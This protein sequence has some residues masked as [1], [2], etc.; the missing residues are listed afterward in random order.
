MSLSFLSFI[1]VTALASWLF[2]FFGRRLAI[3][4]RAVDHPT[5]G[6]K[7]HA[8]PTALWGGIG[9]GLTIVGALIVAERL[10]WLTDP[11]LRP[12]Q[13]AGFIVAILV[14]LVTGALDDR[15]HF[16]PPALFVLYLLASIVVILTGTSIVQVTRIGSHD[17]VRLPALFGQSLA[18]VW[19]MSV[20]FSTKFLDGL[21][22]LVTGQAVIGSLLIAGLALSS[23]YHQPAIVVLAFLIAAA[24]IGFLPHNLYPAKQFLGESGSVLAGFALGFLSIVSGTKVAIALMA[25]GLPLADA[26]LVVLGRIVR[27][28]SPFRGDDTHLHFKLLKAGLSQRQVVMLLWTIAAAFGLAALAVQT[29]GKIALGIAL[30]VLTAI[31]SFFADV[32]RKSRRTDRE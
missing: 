13:L 25:L 9:I 2:A 19:L 14:I 5:G 28:A 12:L 3:K 11:H 24:F 17:G 27:G 31:L 8:A 10:G 29:R 1:S 21:D 6:R 18:L 22:G 20:T 23:A 7:I 4:V 16:S 26:T 30:I 32:M 15:F